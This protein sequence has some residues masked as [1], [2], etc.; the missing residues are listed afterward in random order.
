MAIA[1][2]D[3]LKFANTLKSAGVPDSG[4]VQGNFKELVTKDDLKQ[5]ILELQ[6]ELKQEI[7]NLASDIRIQLSQI[8]GE[9]I[10]LRWMMGATFA[11]G[12]AALGL[13]GRLLFVLP[14]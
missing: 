8:K 4:V 9:Q 14:R 13:L 3:T 1:T 11:C 2:F 10:L 6:T 5:A 7:D 12:L